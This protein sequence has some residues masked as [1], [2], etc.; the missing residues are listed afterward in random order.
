M[1]V[2]MYGNQ[3]EFDDQQRLNSHH[4]QIIWYNPIVQTTLKE[5]KIM[6]YFVASE[7]QIGSS[8]EKLQ[9]HKH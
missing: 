1:P 5:Q 9:V 7:K 3:R 2:K 6:P 4:K 8:N